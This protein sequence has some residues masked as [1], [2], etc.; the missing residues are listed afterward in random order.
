MSSDFPV[1]KVTYSDDSSYTNKD[2]KY[3]EI[4]RDKLKLF[5]ILRPNGTSRVTFHIKSPDQRLIV[6]SR[7]LR[8]MITSVIKERAWLIGYQQT[9]QGVNLQVIMCLFQDGSIE[10]IDKFYDDNQ[11]FKNINLR[12]EEQFWETEDDDA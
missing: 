1:W 4:D 8:D 7:V 11:F 12:P 3:P 9:K 10:I 5:Q 2:I 6:R